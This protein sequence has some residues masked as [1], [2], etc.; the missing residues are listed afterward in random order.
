[1]CIPLL[2]LIYEKE[3]KHPTFQEEHT[4]EKITQDWR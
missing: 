2:A 3:E 4:Q 1:M